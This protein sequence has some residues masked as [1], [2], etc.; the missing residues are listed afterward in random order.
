MS[1]QTTIDVNAQAK[2]LPGTVLECRDLSY[3]FPNSKIVFRN[4]SLKTHSDEL[5][6]VVE[7]TGTG[8]STL[9]RNLLQNSKGV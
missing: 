4:V 1:T 6:A 9:L 7:P 2:P 8:K 3:T 5:V